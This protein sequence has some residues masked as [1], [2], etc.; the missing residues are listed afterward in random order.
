MP[1]LRQK[2]YL[3]SSPVG[4]L[5]G[6]GGA[7]GG[8]GG[9]LGGSGGALGGGGGALGGVSPPGFP[10]GAGAVPPGWP[11]G[12]VSSGNSVPHSTHFFTVGALI[13]PHLGHFLVCLFAVGGRK[14]MPFF[15]FNK[16]YP[17]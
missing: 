7:L 11:G 9:A 15:S 3:L 17:A 4:G 12:G 8:A 5:G 1:P 10:G 13:V 16:N 14:H 2:V 6:A